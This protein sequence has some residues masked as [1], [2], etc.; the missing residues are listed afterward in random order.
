MLSFVGYSR[1]QRTWGEILWKMLGCCY[2]KLTVNLSPGR[3]LVTVRQEDLETSRSLVNGIIWS[4]NSMISLIQ[5]ACQWIETLCTTLNFSPMLNLTT[6]A[7]IGCLQLSQQRWEDK[8]M[9]IWLRVE[10]SHP[11]AHGVL[12]SSSLG[13]RLESW[14]WLL[15]IV[16]WIGRPKRMSTHCLGLTTYWINL[17]MLVFY[18]PLI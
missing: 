18:L 17:Y 8:W 2:Y 12:V 15:I 6:D 9:K 1:L 14:E 3:W 5:L 7:N 4:N 10:L 11:V 13:R 16:H